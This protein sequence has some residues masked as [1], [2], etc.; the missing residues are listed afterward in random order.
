[1]QHGTLLKTTFKRLLLL[2]ARAI[3]GRLV[4]YWKVVIAL[5]LYH[6]VRKGAFGSEAKVILN[7]TLFLDYVILIVYLNIFKRI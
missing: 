1:M 4:L 7:E 2:I 3:F 5:L 6:Y